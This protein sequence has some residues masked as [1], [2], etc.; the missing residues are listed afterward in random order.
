[1]LFDGRCRAGMLF[2]ISGNRDGARYL[3]GGETR[4][5]RVDLA[6]AIRKLASVA[7]KARRQNEL[8]LIR[9]RMVR[10]GKATQRFISRTVK[11]YRAPREHYAFIADCIHR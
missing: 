5:V 8:S 10:S 11:P 6:A 7:L 2:D 1:M 4:R 9:T 3:R